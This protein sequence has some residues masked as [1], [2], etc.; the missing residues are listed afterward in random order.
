[1]LLALLGCTKKESQSG[2]QGKQIEGKITISGAFALYPLVNVWAS[3]FKKEYPNIRINISGGGAGKG[4]A[5]VMTG[6]VDIGMFSREITDAEK[7]NGVW[8]ISVSRDAVIPTISAQ[9]PNLKTIQ[10]KGM[11]KSQLS[12]IFLE[13]AKV[14]WFDSKNDVMVYT[15]SDAAGAAATWAEYLGGKGQ[16]SL[17]GIA[18]F[19]DP[20]V[21]D[22]VKKDPFALGFNNIIYVY[23]INTGQKYPGMDVLPIDLNNN[24]KIDQEENFYGTLKDING[25]IADGKYPSP[26]SR[27]LYLLAKGAPQKEPVKLFL[28]WVLTTGQNFIV[29]NGY[30]PL[31]E[32]VLASQ[33]NKLK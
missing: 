33:K 32:D 27:D 20:G 25:A 2:E 7:A 8:W 31:K 11:T 23:D 9:N 13:D 21:A 22:A 4:M 26:P 28:N 16:E 18:V 29:A 5:D 19:G 6:A 12:K 10:E 15:R 17:K 24:G 1:M 30:I 14:K 3:E